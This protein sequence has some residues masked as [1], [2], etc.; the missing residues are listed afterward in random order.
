MTLMTKAVE[1]AAHAHDGML[2]KGTSIP[3]ITHPMEVAAIAAVLTDDE[4]ILA[5]ALLHDVMEDCGVT[6]QELLPRFGARVAHLVRYATQERTG[7][8]RETWLKRK[9]GAVERLIHGDWAAR[10]IALGDKLS[11]M[12]AIRRDY[13]RDGDALFYRFHQNDK[14]KIAWYYRSCLSVLEADFGQSA[15]WQELSA[16]IDY[17]FSGIPFFSPEEDEALVDQTAS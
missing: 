12:R 3:Y 10:V 4:E 9:L 16:H 15:A 1:F 14:R 6:E 17:V 13:D 7:D 11:N 5:A 2:R 8:P